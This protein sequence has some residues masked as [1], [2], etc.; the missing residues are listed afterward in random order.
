MLPDSCDQPFTVSKVTLYKR[1]PAHR[2]PMSARQ[3]VE[4]DRVVSCPRQHLAGM[5]AN[6]SGSAGNEY[7]LRHLD[8]SSEILLCDNSLSF[9]GRCERAGTCPHFFD[10]W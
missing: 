3:I 4:N 6:V 9:T 8:F 10:C 7:R 2:L 5:T 1:P